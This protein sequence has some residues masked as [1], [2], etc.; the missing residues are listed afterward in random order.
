MN[1]QKNDHPKW[2]KI[3]QRGMLRFVFLYGF[4]GFGLTATLLYH[5]GGL[6]W[7]HGLDVSMYFGSGWERELIDS[8]VQWSLTGVIWGILMW[9]FFVKRVNK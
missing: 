1:N 7:K 9:F 6:I 3:K 8:L 5:F 4:L 2:S